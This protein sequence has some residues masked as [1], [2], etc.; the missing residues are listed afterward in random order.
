MTLHEEVVTHQKCPFC[1]SRE[2]VPGLIF[3]V[4]IPGG[5][6]GGGGGGVAETRA[7]ARGVKGSGSMDIVNKGRKYQSLSRSNVN[8]VDT[9]FLGRSEEG[10]ISYKRKRRQLKGK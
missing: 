5:T 4:C 9:R 3:E 1:R 2:P 6:G 8:M 10:R 7:E